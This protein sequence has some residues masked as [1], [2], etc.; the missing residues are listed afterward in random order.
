MYQMTNHE[1]ENIRN[2]TRE[3]EKSKRWI[4]RNRLIINKKSKQTL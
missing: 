2:F 4:L 1:V 3:L